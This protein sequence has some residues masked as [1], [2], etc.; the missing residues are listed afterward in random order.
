M[1]RILLGFLGILVHFIATGQSPVF[2]GEFV[3]NVHSER[4]SEQFKNYRVVELDALLLEQYLKQGDGNS[5]YRSLRLDF[6]GEMSWQ[7]VLL[8]KDIR[9]VDFELQVQTERGVAKTPKGEN[10]TYQGNLTSPTTG[11]ARLT[12]N[13]HFIYGRVKTATE[14]WYI[15]PLKRFSPSAED[16]QY[17]LYKASETKSNKKYKCAADDLQDHPRQMGMGHLHHNDHDHTVNRAVGQCYTTE[18]AIAADFQMFNQFGNTTDTENYMIGILNNVGTDYDDSFDDEIEF[19]IVTFFISTCSTCDPWTSSNNAADLLFSF[20]DWGNSGGFG[21][22]FYDVATLWT[23]RDFAGNTLGVAWVGGLCTNLRYNTCQDFSSNANL[24]RVLQSHELGH[25][26]NSNHDGSGGFI[27]SPSVSTSN[28]WSNQS[29]NVISNFITNAAGPGCL[30]E[31]VADNPPVAGIFTPVTHV[32]PGSFVPFI[33]NSQNEPTSWEWSFSGGSPSTSTF[34]NPLVKYNNIGTFAAT[35]TVENS[36]GFDFADATI[37]VDENGTKYLLYETFENGLVLWDIENPDNSTTWTSA[38]VNFANY[39]TNAAFI[40][41]FNYNSPGQNDYLI[42]PVIDL[43][44]EGNV[45]LEIDYAYARFNSANSDRMLIE[46]STDGGNSFPF[47]VFTGQENGSGNFATVSDQTTAFNPASTN[48]WCYGT[49]FGADCISIDLSQFS[50]ETNF[51]FRIRNETDFGNNLYVDNI[52]LS[53]SCQIAQPPQANFS[54][55]FFVGCAPLPVQF[56]DESI[57]PVTDRQWTFDGGDPPTS[58]EA[59]PFIV[60]DIPGSYDVTLQVGNPAGFSIETKEDFVLVLGPPTAEFE[61]NV[62]GL[63]VSF[64]NLTID[65]NSYEWDFGDGNSSSDE[66]PTH[67]YEMAGDYTVILT[68]EN[69]CGEENF[70]LQITVESPL[71]A[72]FY[73]DTTMGCVPFNVQFT[74]QSEGDIQSWQWTFEGAT[75]DTSTAQNPMVAYQ[76]AG[77]F[78]VQLIV[79]DGTNMD[80]LQ[81]LTYIQADSLPVADYDYSY[82]LGETEVMFADSSLNADSIFWDFGDGNTSS[83]MNPINNYSSDSTYT[84]TLIAVNNCGADTTTQEIQIITLP[85][86]SIT[87]DTTSGCLPFSVQFAANSP[88]GESF[89]WIFEGGAPDSSTLEN[90]SIL[91]EEA[92]TFDVI[93]IV[94]NAAGQFNDTMNAFIT[95]LEPPTA[96]FDIEYT[97]GETESTFVNTSTAADSYFWD[98]GDGNTSTEESPVH[99]YGTD[100]TYTISLIATNACGTDTTMQVLDVVTSPDGSISADT[101]DGCAPMT[102]N[103]SSNSSNGSSYAW[104]FEGGMPFSSTESNPSVV[105]A[106]AGTFSVSLVIT[107]AAGDLSLMETEYITVGSLPTASFD[108]EYTIGETESTFVN[109][110]TAADSYFWDFGDGNTSTEES[111]VHDYGTD[112]TYTISLI[113]TNACGTDTTMQVLDVVTPPQGAISSDQEEG[114]APLTIQFFANSANAGSYNWVFEGG[115]PAS[116]VD[117]NPIVLYENA[118][119]YDVS[120]MLTNQAGE[121]SIDLT[122][123]IVVEELPLAD[124]EVEVN[125]LDIITINNSINAD[126]Y[127]W[128]FGDGMTSQEEIPIHTYEEPGNYII[129]LL[130]ENACGVDTLSQSIVVM[131]NSLGALYNEIVLDVFPN[132]NDGIFWLRVNGLEGIYPVRIKVYNVAG[133]LIQSTQQTSQL[134]PLQE[135]YNWSSLSAGLYILQVEIGGRIWHKRLIIQD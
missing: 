47:T 83:E 43:S 94:T 85:K 66:N 42:S 32:C 84:V 25:N 110:S 26:F 135:D 67:L 121:T 51:R 133:Q 59:N 116:S 1:H 65:A 91:Y 90:P 14:D 22:V 76:N 49:D 88:N 112:G 106:T 129:S 36:L 55:D 21:G 23:N 6:G 10:I 109:T 99:D 41:N 39:G 37:Q 2:Q 89:E 122:D 92:G 117:E 128:D 48:D 3:Y 96:S 97:I 82:I 17:L 7:L 123:A 18:I 34:Q 31:C 113:A 50:G 72:A 127:F 100:G 30:A 13:G 24:L 57:G 87:A 107:N 11:L 53:S 108:I 81:Q 68:A 131:P 78:M 38:A 132:P 4:L 64:T 98:F 40:N 103:F 61:A 15:E 114:C 130:V 126:I 28:T 102:V 19:E 46:V 115:T 134:F 52:R 56:M 77:T 104:T 20:R 74:D 9:S 93:L 80:T 79:N 29:I 12:I 105:Y 35:L 70:E 118:G 60:Y 86:A 73:A 45:M 54:A 16:N 101:S 5:P 71:T 58:T 111:P 124:F 95:V 33:D 44:S 27:M 120:L 63:E 8:P 62:N 75:P 125:G 119:L 69:E